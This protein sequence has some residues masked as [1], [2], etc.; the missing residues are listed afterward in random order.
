MTRAQLEPSIQFRKTLGLHIAAMQE[1]RPSAPVFLAADINA[2]RDD[3]DT[4]KHDPNGACQSLLERQSV[5]KCLG[6][7]VDTFRSKHPKTPGHTA[8]GFG[9]DSKHTFRL[10]YLAAPPTVKVMSTYVDY[11]NTVSDHYPLIA[12]YSFGYPTIPVQKIHLLQRKHVTFGPAYSSDDSGDGPSND[13]LDSPIPTEVELV[14]LTLEILPD[15][16]TPDSTIITAHALDDDPQF[17][18]ALG[19]MSPQLNNLSLIHI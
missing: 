3:L 5:T 7:L 2:I 11:T 8:R 9:P 16:E 19:I 14:D 4:T 13:S 6:N 1:R 10:D 12:E 17:T 15:G 18:S